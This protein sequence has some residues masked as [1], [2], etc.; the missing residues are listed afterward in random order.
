MARALDLDRQS[1][2]A[3]RGEDEWGPARHAFQLL[4]WT[5]TALVLLA[6]LDKLSGT[7][8]RWELYVS[9]EVAQIVPAASLVRAAGL[10]EIGIG[11]VVALRPRVGGYLLAAWLSVIVV[12]LVIGGVHLDVALQDFALAVA[13]IALAR[14]ASIYGRVARPDAPRIL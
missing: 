6:G 12:N 4:H 14:L 9:A 5:L 13:A 8:V 11:L 7:F 10:V 2:T 3:E 1:V